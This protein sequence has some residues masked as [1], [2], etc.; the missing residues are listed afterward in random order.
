FDDVDHAAH[1]NGP[2]APEVDAALLVVDRAIAHLLQGIRE[3]G[4]AGRVN[5]VVV[6]DH[7]LETTLPERRSYLDDLFRADQASIITAGVVAGIE[8]NAGHAAEVERALLAPHP[9]MNCSRKAD[10]PAR[11]HYGTHARIPAIVCL[12]VAGGTITTHAYERDRGYYAKGDHG[13]DNELPSMR[14]L[15]LAN[16]PAFRSGVIVPAFE[17]VDVY[18]LLARV[19]GIRPA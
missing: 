5:L 18:P 16:G 19:L 2:D 6:S 4:L 15:F 1:G 9:W 3:R 17:G 14:A 11:L 12:A 13:Y 7:G 8:P 10:L